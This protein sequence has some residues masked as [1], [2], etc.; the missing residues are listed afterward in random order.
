M[1]DIDGE[2]WLLD[3]SLKSEN[4]NSRRHTYCN[5]QLDTR[6]AATFLHVI[7]KKET[8]KLLSLY[9]STDQHT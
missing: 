2:A 3:E 9:C 4:I 1:T 5:K 7:M 8:V 6:A